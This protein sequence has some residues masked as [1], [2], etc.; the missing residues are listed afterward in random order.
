MSFS[1]TIIILICGHFLFYPHLSTLKL[2]NC[3]NKHK[4]MSL[5][6]KGQRCGSRLK[7]NIALPNSSNNYEI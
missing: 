7:N 3:I 4:N 6:T 1:T 2:R 5:T